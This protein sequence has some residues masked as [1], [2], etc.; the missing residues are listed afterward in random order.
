[1]KPLL[2]LLICLFA[3]NSIQA[4]EERTAK[5]PD[6]NWSR[7]DFAPFYILEG[8]FENDGISDNVI[9]LLSKRIKGYHHQAVAMTLSRMLENARQGIP[10]CHVALRKTAKREVF[11]E[12]SDPIMINY[13]NGIITSKANLARF[14]MSSDNIKEIDFRSLTKQQLN[15]SIHEGRSY[16]PVIDQVI[17]ETINQPDSIFLVKSGKKDQDRL[18]KL[19][20]AERL[21][22]FIARPEEVYFNKISSKLAE[23][24]FLI[25]IEGQPIASVVH[26]GCTKGE[27]NDS[28]LEQINQLTKEEDIRAHINQNY[29]RWLPEQLKKRYRQDQAKF[30]AR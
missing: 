20:L 28:L 26:V 30:F 19:L 24:L 12:Y 1:M 22:G 21:D 18:I 4:I 29:M 13:A 25:G 10:T 8:E 15:I 3:C 17:S 2:T 16:S 9:K 5:L 14:G 27:W 23:P 11:I 6:V 7:T